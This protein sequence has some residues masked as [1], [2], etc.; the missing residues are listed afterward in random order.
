M[1]IILIGL[2]IVVIR[3]QWVNLKDIQSAIADADIDK[4]SC[5]RLLAITSYAQ[6]TTESNLT[7]RPGTFQCP[8]TIDKNELGLYN[9]KYWQSIN[10][11]FLTGK[12]HWHCLISDESQCDGISNCLTD[13][14]GC[15]KDVFKCA[16][17]LGCISLVN[18]CNGYKDCMDGSDEC[19]CED[20]VTCDYGIEQYCIPREKYISSSNM[21][22]NCTDRN[23]HLDKREKKLGQ[24]FTQ[25]QVCLMKFYRT[26]VDI[27]FFVDE[28]KDYSKW[29]HANCNSSYSQ[30]CD[31]IKFSQNEFWEIK[32]ECDGDNNKNHTVKQLDVKTI[33]DG[34]KNCEDMTDE[35][36]CPGRHYCKGVASETNFW[37]D[38]SLI[39]NLHKDCP[40]GDDEC[41]DC[42]GKGEAEIAVES[43]TQMIQ[44]TSIKVLIISES[45]LI[46]GLNIVAVWDISTKATESEFVKVDQLAV[47]S[48]CVYDTL[49]GIYLGYIFIK[50]IMFSGDYCINDYQ[51]R[52]SLQCKA[53]G[54]V[55]TLSAHGSLLII[56]MIS[57]T[58][59][60]KC[61]LGREISLKKA[62][63]ILL[64]LHI[65]N[66]AH[67]ILPIIPLSSLQDVFR[68]Y[69]SF[70]KNPFFKEYDAG[71]LIRKYLVY[72]GINTTVPG[73]YTMLE[74]LNNASTGGK[75]FD[76]Q[77]L[78]YYSYSALCIHNIY[79]QQKSL[80]IYRIPYMIATTI[81]LA[82]IITSYISIIMHAYKT[83]HEVNQMAA[84]A[85][86]A[87]R[88]SKDLSVKVMLMIGSQLAC[89]ITV[90]ILTVIFSYIGAGPT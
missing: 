62:R 85:N 68:A 45:V 90:M 8:F 43:D 80:L 73:T 51:W 83:S 44:H 11:H 33:C 1:I 67:S 12:V 7:S 19:M 40:L 49:M 18:V 66:I 29:C 61:V 86:P 82:A 81:L 5:N 55:F 6:I 20:I 76:P 38:S 15:G 47:I 23:L 21:Y 75:M 36:A 78:G 4:K 37:V 56:A 26:E 87:A 42:A 72:F 17:G 89:W 32:F 69:M 48:L 25:L 70:S 57:V 35:I 13:E 63:C 34:V 14:C 88:T 31:Q 46:L 10:E 74:H 41:Q 59:W 58:R 71:E 24:D 28:G 53:L 39:C 22:T 30:F 79:S 50:S 16:D 3:C 60:Y 64:L 84:N 54:V 27:L 9:T 65:T 2:L 77:E 52:S